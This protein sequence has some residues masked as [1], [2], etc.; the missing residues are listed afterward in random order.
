MGILK[1]DN[2]RSGFWQFAGLILL[3]GCFLPTA[4]GQNSPSDYNT[5]VL[6]TDLLTDGETCTGPSSSQANIFVTAKNKGWLYSGFMYSAFLQTL[7]QY[8]ATHGYSQS[9]TWPS[10]SAIN[11]S[12]IF[13]LSSCDYSYCLLQRI[14]G[15][16]PG[17]FYAYGSPECPSTNTIGPEAI[18]NLMRVINVGLFVVVGIVVSYGVIGKGILIGGFEGDILQKNFTIATASRIA[19]ATFS[20]I[21]MPGIGYS[22]MQAFIMWVALL[23][24]GLADSTY[25]VGLNA[26]LSYGAIFSYSGFGDSSTDQTNDTTNFTWSN[27]QSMFNVSAAPSGAK[28]ASIMTQMSCGIYNVVTQKIQNYSP[29]DASV[30]NDAITSVYTSPQSVTLDEIMSIDTTSSWTTVTINFGNYYD[31]S[32]SNSCGSITYTMPS[33]QSPSEF[34]STAAY[35]MLNTLFQQ[36]SSSM[37]QAEQFYLSGVKTQTETDYYTC[38]TGNNIMFDGL[39]AYTSATN[40]VLYRPNGIVC[41]YDPSTSIRQDNISTFVTLTSPQASSSQ[42]FWVSGCSGNCLSQFANDLVNGVADVMSAGGSDVTEEMSTS[43]LQA[44]NFTSGSALTDPTSWV[45]NTNNSQFSESYIGDLLVLTQAYKQMGWSLTANNSYNNIYTNVVQGNGDTTSTYGT[46]TLS[47]SMNVNSLNSMVASM[48]APFFGSNPVDFINTTGYIITWKNIAVSA[49]NFTTSLMMITQRL[50]G[51][52]FYD[53]S[54]VMNINW[55]TTQS[56]NTSPSVYSTCK[57]TY[58][59]NCMGSNVSNCFN[60][61]NNAGCFMNSDGQGRGLLGSVAMMYNVGTDDQT[62][63][64]SIYNPMSDYIEIGYTILVAA[65]YYLYQNS[66]DIIQL[67]IEL[68]AISFA[69]GAVTDIVKAA[70]LVMAS[71]VMP[72]WLDR[73]SAYL[74]IT[75]IDTVKMV[76]D[77]FVQLDAYRIDFYTT[78]GTTFMILFVP[79]GAML[80]ILLPFYPTVIFIV[81]AFGWI[82]SLVEAMIAGPMVA[83]GL[84][85]PEGHDF[86]GKAEMG[87]GILFQMFLRPVLIVMGVFLSIS[88]IN[89]AFYAFNIAYATQYSY[90]AGGSSSPLGAVMNTFNNWEV[91]LAIVLVLVMLYAYVAWQLV[92]Y[93]CSMMITMSNEVLAWVSSG[94]DSRFV[95]VT[96][97]MASTK[98]QFESAAT[99][100]ARSAGSISSSTSGLGRQI[101]HLGGTDFYEGMKRKLK[102]G[103]DGY[104]MSAVAKKAYK[105]AGDTVES[106]M[107]MAQQYVRANDGSTPRTIQEH[108]NVPQDRRLND[109]ERA[110]A[111]QNVANS[112][113]RLYNQHT[114]APSITQN[115]V[116]YMSNIKVHAQVASRVQGSF[117]DKASAFL[118][119]TAREHTIEKTRAVADDAIYRAEARK[120]AKDANNRMRS[121]K[122]KK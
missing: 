64:L 121:E 93:C 59:S 26:Y 74:I 101:K 45:T 13:T 73:P 91:N 18:G 111:R 83:I 79:F 69:A 57:N 40:K 85:H 49:N 112:V 68:T 46:S 75:V 37:Y 56:Q 11:T 62:T 51:F 61:M 31:G 81:G 5:F 96:E 105:F 32:D 104:S 19:V 88:A 1:R 9:Y 29:Y 66:Q 24:V 100:V 2:I 8:Q 119:Y 80:A 4:S 41:T 55:Y 6:P 38:L 102:E 77:F 94:S 50:I 48:L 35:S 14:F 27:V 39:I 103:E 71:P 15:E 7:N 114:L 118:G 67:Y 87:F 78:L 99:G 43:Q 76:V 116:G 90:L 107:K 23:G 25:R 106:P 44:Y 60:A 92:S 84:C 3:L 117:A 63:Q 36:T 82:A 22:A 53:P 10:G 47:S 86:L 33:G 110:K 28:Y 97:V 72:P 34:T 108:L 70:V 12:D 89:L 42:I 30:P 122:Q 109:D 115:P 95:N 120:I 21:P 16:M 17:L 58:Q 52:Y 113:D 54:N 65:S 20:I 98:S